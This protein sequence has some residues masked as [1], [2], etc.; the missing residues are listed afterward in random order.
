MSRVDT[1]FYMANCT[2]ARKLS[3]SY[4]EHMTQIRSI[5]SRVR[6]SPSRAQRGKLRLFDS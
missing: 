3:P 1:V 5:C 4:F 2:V 6:I